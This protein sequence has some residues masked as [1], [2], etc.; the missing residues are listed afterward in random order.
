M[1]KFLSYSKRII[2]CGLSAMLLLT[3]APDTALLK[4][5]VSYVQAA[6]PGEDLSDNPG[7]EPDK[8]EVG[9]YPYEDIYFESLL[10]D[11]ILETSDKASKVSYEDTDGGI[12]I[13][14]KNA[15]FSSAYVKITQALDF[16]TGCANRIRL[17]AL[18][19]RATKVKAKFYLDDE[20]D[21]FLETQLKFQSKKDDWTT[22]QPVFIEIPEGTVKGSHYLTIKFE[23]TTTA[24]DK[25]AECFLRSIKFYKESVP[26]VNINIDESYTP[27]ADMNADP[28][29]MTECYGSIDITV[30]KDGA[31]F[32]YSDDYEGGHYVLDY[33][34]G[35]GNSTWGADK[36]PY[37]I[38]LDKSADLFGM[39]KNKHWTLIANYYDNSLV[40]NRLTYYLGQQ[41]DMQFT[42]QLVPVDVVMN[43]KYLGGYYLCEQIRVGESRV[44]INNL[45]EIEPGDED[46]SGGYLLGVSPYG[47][48]EGYSFNTSHAVGMVV[49]SPE[50]LENKDVPAERLDEMNQYIEDYVNK[51]EAAIFGNGFKDEDGH[52]YTEYMDLSS[53]AKYYLIQEFSANGDAY[54]TTSTHLYKDKNGKLCWGPLWD[55]DYVAWAS[56]YY[57]DYDFDDSSYAGFFTDFA[58][59]E[60]LKAD[61][62]FVNEVNKVWGGKESEDPK[63]LCYQLNELIKDGGVLDQYADEMESSAGNNFDKW[64][65][66]DFGG[67]WFYGDYYGEDGAPTMIQCANQRE[68]IARLKKWISKRMDWFDENIK[69]MEV[70]TYKI[71][72]SVD[73]KQIAVKDAIGNEPFY[74]FP[75]DPK[76]DGYVF[77]GWYADFEYIDPDTGETVTFRDSLFRGCGVDRDIN[78]EAEWIKKEDVIPAKEVFLKYKEAYLLTGDAEQM[79]YSVLPYEAGI[80]GVKFTST[81]ESIATVNDEGYISTVEGRTGDVTITVETSNGKKDSCLLHVVYWDDIAEYAE[82]FHMSE[83][84]VTV[85]AGEWKKLDF[86]T[87]PANLRINQVNYEIINTDDEIAFMDSTGVVEARKEGKA[88]IV[89][90]A[91]DLGSYVVVNVTVTEGEKKGDKPEDKD[92]DKDDIPTPTPSPTPSGNDNQEGLKPGD[93]FTVGKLVYEVIEPVKVANTTA[94]KIG[95]ASPCDAITGE[96]AASNENSD[97]TGANNTAASVGTAKVKGIVTKY[98]KKLTSI[99]IPETV[100]NTDGEY[101]IVGIKAGA[102]KN[103]KKLKTVTIG[104]NVTSIE[105]NAFSGCK[106]LKKVTI[107]SS[108]TTFGKN[109][110][111]KIN[112][113]AKFY[114]PKKK[115]TTYRK[116]LKKLGIKKKQVSAIKTTKKT[117][118]KKA[119]NTSKKTTK[120][121]TSSSKKTTK[122]TTK[123]SK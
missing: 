39:G 55:F 7:G 109:V 51:T 83:T 80:G 14:G 33:I 78:V 36:K 119:T 114:V 122:K 106:N 68:E 13:S 95:M 22:S 6:E 28:G 77:N 76:K 120:S 111:K 41:L 117:T 8:E 86:V 17:D 85:K 87:T 26:T 9:I 37:K 88:K 61:P 98:K 23:D 74:D 71:T 64:G 91:K 101:K 29:H 66:T 44:E 53:A 103:S 60:R 21:A 100:K 4:G 69:Y 104:K 113:N 12:L 43:G 38:K 70:P 121:S 116:Q 18:T 89:V 58:W 25:K 47:D 97:L 90:Y 35:R 50:E 31:K 108:K 24:A 59:F 81:D 63:T 105:K 46:I 40:R 62:S 32:G 99:S 10:I 92:K 19:K 110:F 75:E 52:Y 5:A 79:E 56:T 107:N 94:N 96:A 118:K 72:F 57:N 82:E 45:E 42:P 3:A 11:E 73:G 112:K 2:A 67:W 123:K 93:T 49:E 102:F 34:R 16:G 20:E 84:D 54:R 30:P 15:N 27:I 48:E 115:L 65:M 1:K